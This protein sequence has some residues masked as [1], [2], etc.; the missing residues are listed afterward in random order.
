MFEAG[1]ATFY[2]RGSVGFDESLAL[3]AQIPIKDQWIASRP[4]LAALRGYIVQIP[5]SGTLSDPRIDQ[6]ALERLATD[7]L[8]RATGQILQDELN[9]GLQRWLGPGQ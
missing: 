5:I 3:T 1:R 2:T 8:R 6:R 9:K 4:Q 7:T